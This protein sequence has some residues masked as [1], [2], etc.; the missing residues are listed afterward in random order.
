MFRAPELVGAAVPPNLGVDLATAGREIN[1]S[2]ELR[3]VAAKT[4]TAF[5]F[6]LARTPIPLLRAL[7]TSN[8]ISSSLSARSAEVRG[9]IRIRK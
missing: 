5:Y 4:L 9:S 7:K 8:S 1:S 6:W 3:L 2:S